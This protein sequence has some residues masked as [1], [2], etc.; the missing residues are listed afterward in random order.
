[1][2]ARPARR[3]V[4]GG[5]GVIADIGVTDDLPD[6]V[7]VTASEL[8]VIETYLGNLFDQILAEAK[9]SVSAPMTIRSSNRGKTVRASRPRP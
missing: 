5:K 7:P 2:A 1:M 6:L 4:G 8:A 3:P 9:A